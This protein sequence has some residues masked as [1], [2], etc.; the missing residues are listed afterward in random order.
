MQ[1][2]ITVR[3]SSMSI[4]RPNAEF[5]T[6]TSI[7]VS[8]LGPP[9][10][11]DDSTSFFG[12]SIAGYHSDPPEASLSQLVPDVRCVILLGDVYHE[13]LREMGDQLGQS[14]EPLLS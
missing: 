7:R 8:G 4:P 11:I 12:R 1:A 5:A 10:V 2:W 13:G 9:P 14:L 3:I 6:T